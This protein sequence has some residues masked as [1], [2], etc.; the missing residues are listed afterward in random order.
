[1]FGAV[2]LLLLSA[3]AT[4]QLPNKERPY[5][6]GVTQKSSE[7]AALPDEFVFCDRQKGAWRCPK[8]TEKTPIEPNLFN[9]DGQHSQRK[10]AETA[11]AFTSPSDLKKHF[12]YSDIVGE[13]LTQV[14]FNVASYSLT[15]DSK[16]IISGVLSKLTGK[17]VLVFGFT[18]NAG[19]ELYN[20]VLALNRAESVKKFLVQNGIPAAEIH[21]E[22][23]GICCF[24][25]PNATDEQRV[26]NRRVEIYF[27][28]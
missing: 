6:L 22:G 14:H 5:I 23:N 27:A 16:G 17:P 13:P 15:D 21:V 3:C 25:V 18:D 7:N 1:M 19:T 11:E 28:E 26:I 9:P 8:V 2:T 10:A 4:Q 12:N 24:L 20:D